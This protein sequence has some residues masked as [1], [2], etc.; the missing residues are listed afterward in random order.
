[1]RDLE[2]LVAGF[3]RNATPGARRQVVDYL[4]TMIRERL[5]QERDDAERRRLLLQFSANLLAPARAPEGLED[6]KNLLARTA[7]QEAMESAIKAASEQ[8]RPTPTPQPSPGPRPGPG[9]TM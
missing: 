8:Q 1:M 9:M 5:R 7:S 4:P 3:S 6:A 2:K